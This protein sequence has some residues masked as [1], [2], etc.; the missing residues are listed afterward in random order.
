M[1]MRCVCTTRCCVKTKLGFI[2][3]PNSFM[4]QNC[5]DGH[6]FCC[7]HK[8]V[9]FQHGNAFLMWALSH[10]PINLF[11]LTLHHWPLVLNVVVKRGRVESCNTFNAMLHIVSIYGFC[12]WI[13]M[14]PGTSFCVCVCVC[15]KLSNTPAW[16]WWLL[17]SVFLKAIFKMTLY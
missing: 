11:V 3:S 13:W 1:F 12:T 8:T 6:L 15:V 17:R 10:G 2:A 5:M 9:K 4:L 7:F 16:V 14:L